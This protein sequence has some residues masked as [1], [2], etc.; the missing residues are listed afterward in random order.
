M[1]FYFNSRI[2]LTTYSTVS[3]V[4]GTRR[5]LTDPENGKFDSCV[6]L[7]TRVLSRRKQSHH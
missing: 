4:G 2:N 1:I 3:R 6:I 5:V 7:R